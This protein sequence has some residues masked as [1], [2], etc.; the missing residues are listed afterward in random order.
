MKMR[1]D[2]EPEAGVDE[3]RG[4]FH[5]CGVGIA[6]RG[7][8]GR[9]NGGRGDRGGRRIGGVDA[10]EDV[11]ERGPLREALDVGEAAEGDFAALEFIRDLR[12]GEGARG[13]VGGVENGDSVHAMLGHSRT[14]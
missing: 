12:A 8:E 13:R 4:R 2:A 5:R 3:M 7:R 6:G 10:R 9:G 14:T 11:A 1:D